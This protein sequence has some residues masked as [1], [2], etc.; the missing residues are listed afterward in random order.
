MTLFTFFARIIDFTS[1]QADTLEYVRRVSVCV[2]VECIGIQ[3][4]HGI[5][6]ES[7]M[8]KNCLCVA[9]AIYSQGARSVNGLTTRP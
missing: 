4:S 2:S 7:F 3:Q 6:I 1:S 9:N 8:H 5:Q